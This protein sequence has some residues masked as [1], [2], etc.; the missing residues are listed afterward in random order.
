MDR[1][2]PLALLMCVCAATMAVPAAD[3]AAAPVAAGPSAE[4]AS[5]P[6][7]GKPM[8]PATAA[9]FGRLRSLI[10]TWQGKTGDGR[11]VTLAYR[12]ISGD[13]CL[14]ET[15]ETG[16]GG[17]MVSIYCPDGDGLLMTH[18][19]AANNQPRMRA[20]KLSG[21]RNVLAFSFV[22]A[23]NLRS[24]SAGHMRGLRITFQ[25]PDHFT[26][27]WTYRHAGK[28]QVDTFSYARTAG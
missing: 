9:A 18:Y 11:P 8:T 12:L 26:Q 3:Q 16:E 22:D 15:L 17:G 6:D 10:G 13:T 24:E 19:C 5:H 7:N 27:D 2:F 21:D 1:T 20:G 14:E 25:D 28:D 4:T 23:S